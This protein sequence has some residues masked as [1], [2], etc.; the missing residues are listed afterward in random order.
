MAMGLLLVIYLAFISL[1]LPDTLLGAAWPVMHGELGVPLGAAGGISFII[2]LCTVVSSLL[3]GKLINRFGTG[4]LAVM[5]VAAT[6]AALFGFSVSGQYVWLLICAVPLGLGAGAV[7]AGL[8]HFVAIHYKAR[9]MNFLHCFWGIGAMAGP[10][11][12]AFAM[13]RL[14]DWRTGYRWVSFL[15][16]ALV[17]VLAL[18]LPLWKKVENKGNC[19]GEDC[20]A[21]SLKAGLRTKGVTRSLLSF[22]LYFSAESAAGLWGSSYLV[23][24]RG[25][26]EERAA[27]AASLFFAGMALGR[28]LSG[29]VAERTSDLRRIQVGGGLALLGVLLLLVP[30]SGWVAI[31]GFCLVG[32]GCAPMQPAMLHETPAR[33]GPTATGTIMGMQTAASYCGSTLMP[34]L[35][36]LLAQ[37]FGMGLLPVFLLAALVLTMAL[38]NPP[39][40]RGRRGALGNQKTGSK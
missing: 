6:A 10:M 35:L 18:S 13:A 20:E 32:L 19:D 8:N 36:G 27:V 17:G 16:F 33:F 21:I 23:R 25:V 11:I 15:Q 3:S 28:C 1:G 39:P 34:P 5:S 4:G 40:K 37:R 38:H 7:D 2:S 31:F 9:H 12:M 22:F 30:G 26:S 14:S 29:L 24:Q